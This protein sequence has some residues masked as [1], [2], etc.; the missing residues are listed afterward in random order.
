MG[1]LKI[2]KKTKEKEKEMRILILGLVINYSK[3]YKIY[4]TKLIFRLNYIFY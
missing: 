1:L 3:I 2:L 4:I